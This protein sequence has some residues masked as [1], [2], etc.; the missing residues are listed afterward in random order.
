MKKLIFG[1]LMFSPLT[2]MAQ[3]N[4]SASQPNLSLYKVDFPALNAA[5]AIGDLGALYKSID[6]G[7]TW[8]EHYNFGPFS[9][10]S[11]VRFI[12]ADTGFVTVGWGQ[13]ITFDGGINWSNLGSFPKVKIC[14]NMLYT[15]YVSHD[16]TYIQKSD[17]Y[18]G[19]WSVLYHHFEVGAQAF[20]LSFINADSVFF[21]NPNELEQAYKTTNGFLTVD[22]VNIFTGDL[23][24]QEEFDFKNM[25]CG[26]LY[27]SWGSLSHPTKAWNNPVNL[28]GFGVLPVLD[29]AFTPSKIYAS[30]LYGKIFVSGNDGMTWTPQNIT[31][32][33]PAM[34]VAFLNE[35]RGIAVGKGFYYTIN[36]GNSTTIHNPQ[37]KSQFKIY[38]NPTN[39]KVNLEYPFEI[40]VQNIHLMDVT[41]RKIKAFFKNEKVLNI[42]DIPRGVYFLSI[43]TKAGVVNEK[44][45]LK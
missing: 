33:A 14:G 6:A 35:N 45:I 15:S 36:G 37:L 5:Y 28:D 22:T 44:I 38:P 26:F 8:T 41:G 13:M 21:I 27:G 19:T 3:W 17:D 10:L 11:D 23:T 34:S 29:L 7:M 32:T 20:L 31:D 30:S 43:Q 16:T 24:L 2:M 18:G 25:D 39:G 12:N 42:N 9:S 40:K 4:K 1:L